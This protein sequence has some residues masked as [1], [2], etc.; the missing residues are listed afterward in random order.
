MN[1]ILIII[2]DIIT[3]SAPENWLCHGEENNDLSLHHK[4]MIY[5]IIELIL[6]GRFK[7]F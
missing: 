4:A 1:H 2:N 5:I 3:T 7:I 6:I